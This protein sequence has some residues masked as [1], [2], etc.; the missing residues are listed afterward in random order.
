MDEDDEQLHD[1]RDMSSLCEEHWCHEVS[2]ALML[3]D[4]DSN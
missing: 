3:A 1:V 2:H 4:Q